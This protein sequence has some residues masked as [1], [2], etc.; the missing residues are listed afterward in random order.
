MR[1]NIIGKEGSFGSFLCRELPK[2]GFE[3]IVGAETII[4]AVPF[5]AYDECGLE[6]QSKHIINCC[7]IQKP[8]TDILLKYT[9][10]VTSIHPLFGARTPIDKRNSIL[11]YIHSRP[12]DHSAENEFIMKFRQFSNII[13][14]I[15]PEKHDVLMAKTH[16]AAIIAAKQA[17]VWVDRAADIPD[18]LIPN[19]FR[20]LREF[21]KTL[22]DMPSGTVSSIM[23]N[24]YI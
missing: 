7:S 11:T 18:E 8:S 19:S 13:E 17:K 1:I 14:G 10:K 4:L 5:S 9:G 16:A 24:P 12:I 6:F 2:H 22:D 23:A 20:L 21:V 15:N 3:I